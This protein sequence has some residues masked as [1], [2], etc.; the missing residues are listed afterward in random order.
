MEKAIPKDSVAV[1]FPVKRKHCLLLNFR[2]PIRES[3]LSAL[4]I[5]GHAARGP[6]GRSSL[7]SPSVSA[8]SLPAL[9]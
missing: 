7:C 9:A 6:G 5:Q 8:L 3:P 4:A 2:R 1:M